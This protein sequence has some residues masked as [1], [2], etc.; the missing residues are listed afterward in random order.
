[1]ATPRQRLSDAERE[2]RLNDALVR[3]VGD[4]I[5]LDYPADVLLD[6]VAAELALCAPKQP[7]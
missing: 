5:A 7:G 6:R 2:R 1:M 4:I 3:F